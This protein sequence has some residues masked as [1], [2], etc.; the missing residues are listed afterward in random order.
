MSKIARNSGG[1]DYECKKDWPENCSV[2]CG[3]WGV[4]VSSKGNYTTAFFEAF[5]RNPNTFI[6]GEGKTVEDAETQAWEEY[7][8]QVNCKE[9]EFE[10]GTYTNGSATCKHCGLFQ[11]KV[12]EPLTKCI[13]CGK[14]ACYGHD[15]NGNIYC[16]EHYESMPDELMKP[17]ML[18]KRKRNVNE[19][20]TTRE[21]L[22]RYKKD[23]LIQKAMNLLFEED[24]VD[25]KLINC[26]YVY[27]YSSIRT[28][29]FL[30]KATYQEH[31][32]CSIDGT[33][34][35]YFIFK[36]DENESLYYKVFFTDKK[37][38]KQIF[39]LFEH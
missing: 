17:M 7:Q 13:V 21:E 4:V 23:E 1:K 22:V 11:T 33:D 18:R 8:K 37:L 32:I 35:D 12:F 28:T 36:D 20:I 31:K 19:N 29:I 26:K 9:H 10:R 27:L 3:D 14:P 30:T 24:A 34:V 6:R 38:I 15:I 25:D 16:E 2:Q 39:E 5:P